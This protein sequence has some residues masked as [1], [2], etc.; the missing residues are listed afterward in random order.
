VQSRDVRPASAIPPMVKRWKKCPRCH[1]DKAPEE[2][3]ADASKPS[4][5]RSRCRECDLEKSR[6]YYRANRERILASANARNARLRA[7]RR[8]VHAPRTCLQCGAE[9]IPRTSRSKRC[10][11][12][13]SD[14][15]ST[16]RASPPTQSLISPVFC[17]R[18]RAHGRGSYPRTRSQA[19]A[20][21]RKPALGSQRRH[22]ARGRT[23]RA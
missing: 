11:S 17:S 6:E 14:G 5:L 4:G 2:F 9:F 23:R 7:S 3:Y 12:C 15:L 18:P 21:G 8:V 20:A 13:A 16:P 22:P 19:S 10:G 1:R